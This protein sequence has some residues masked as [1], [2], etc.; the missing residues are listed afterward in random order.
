MRS[1]KVVV[2][3]R[4]MSAR[5]RPLVIERQG[6]LNSARPVVGSRH[7]RLEVAQRRI[8]RSRS[9]AEGADCPLT[10]SFKA[11]KRRGLR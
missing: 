6:H 8:S 1:R 5:R 9:R 4:V 10:M 2:E 7:L 3:V 11:K